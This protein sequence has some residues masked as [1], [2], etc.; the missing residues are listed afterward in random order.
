MEALAPETLALVAQFVGPRW[1]CLEGLREY[2]QL[3]QSCR[4][5]HE[6]CSPAV[7][8]AK[9]RW[10]ELSR[11]VRIQYVMDEWRREQAQKQQAQQRQA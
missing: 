7:Y 8:R 10:G 6:V 2:H 9:R 4:Q 1:D 5:L 3:Q 11:A